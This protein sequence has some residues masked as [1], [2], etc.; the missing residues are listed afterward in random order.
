MLFKLFIIFLALLF[1]YSCADRI[2]YTDPNIDPILSGLYT[3]IGGEISDTLKKSDS[4]F[5][6]NSNLIVNANDTLRIEPGVTIYFDNG[7]KLNVNG[8]IQA[9]GEKSDQILLTA[10][11]YDW[12]GIHILSSYG[13]SV[14]KFCI[15]GKVSL[16]LGDPEQYGAIEIVN[17]SAEI[18]NCIFK[19]NYTQYGGGISI[20]NSTTEISNNI[21][22][23]NEAEV[24]G[25]AILSQ[26]SSNKIINNTFYKNYCFFFGG[27][28][29]IDEP[30][31]EEI[32]N[33]IFYKNSS[34]TPDPL[35]AIVSGDT[36]KIFEQYNFLSFENMDPLFISETDLHLMPN[37][38][39][40][41]SGNPDPA[42]NDLDG[43]RN[44]QGAYGGPEGDW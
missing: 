28:I 2:L 19:D 44:D 34:Y 32:Q 5:F 40:I 8:V 17:S 9:T 39:C 11:Q 21:F 3:V 29:V 24:Y 31:N 6:V 33:N 37:S 30:V 26:S 10:F 16:Y 43:T 38:P 23:N 7:I 42:F 15:I 13:K 12:A 27:G 36:S 14:F 18:T 20:E 4:P 25:G 35:I 41:D 1:A 22:Y